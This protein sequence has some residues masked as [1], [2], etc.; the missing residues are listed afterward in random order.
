VATLIVTI[1]PGLQ[2]P[3]LVAGGVSLLL[4][5]VAVLHGLSLGRSISL[6]LASCVA[7]LVAILVAL[8][9]SGGGLAPDRLMSITYPPV[10]G[11]RPTPVE[12]DQWVDASKN[13]LQKGRV[14]VY[15]SGTSVWWGNQD[16]PR[17]K[18]PRGLR[19]WVR[20]GNRSMW[21]S[22]DYTSWAGT[23]RI[24]SEPMARL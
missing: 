4:G 14:G 18:N 15:L 24:T 13:A 19:I 3:T 22:L 17:E 11:A 12:P 8:L 23:S 10:P 7:G 6:S 21:G 20:V 16:Q 2:L 9:G 1:L 5:T